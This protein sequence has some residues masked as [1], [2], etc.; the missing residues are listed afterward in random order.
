MK[1][2]VKTNSGDTDI[3]DC[4][5]DDAGDFPAALLSIRPSCCCQAGLDDTVLR[6]TDRNPVRLGAKCRW[7]H[8]TDDAPWRENAIWPSFV[9]ILLITL[10]AAG[11]GPTDSRDQLPPSPTEKS[12]PINIFA[13]VRR[14]LNSRDWA[15]AESLLNQHLENQPT[16]PVALTLAGDLAAQLGKW[17]SAIDH[18]QNLLAI[19][20]QPASVAVRDKLAQAWMG[21]GQPF[22]SIAV[23]QETIQKFPAAVETR[24][25]LAG[26][27]ALLGLETPAVESL[28]WLAQHNQGHPEGL[29][30]LAHPSRLEPDIE[31]CQ[32]ALRNCPEDRRAEYGMARMDAINRRW[33][34]VVDRLEPVVQQRPD[35]VPAIALYGRAIVE[36]GDTERIVKWQQSL[37][38]A[39]ETSALFWETAGR[40]AE[41]QGDDQAAAKAFWKAVQHDQANNSQTLVRLAASLEKI[42]RAD[43][44][45][46][47]ARRADKIAAL[48]DTTNTFFERGSRSQT[49]AMRVAGQ[50]VQL[51]RLWEAEGWARWALEL[52]DEPVADAKRQYISIRSKLTAQTPW[53][54]ASANVT[55]GINLS[56]LPNV[57]W[58]I[59][60]QDPE[61]NSLVNGI[62]KIRF[63]DQAESRRLMHTC[64][65]AAGTEEKGM[66]I[67]QSVGGGA[68][69]LDFDLN[70]WPD[71]SF[72][73]LD[74]QPMQTDSKLNRLFQNLDGQ[75][76]DVTNVSGYLDH[77]FGQGV[78]V[79]DINGDGFPDLLDAN[80]G[81]NRLFQNNGDG[82][83]TDVTQNYVPATVQQDESH[84][85]AADW[86]TSVAIA[87]LNGDGH[88][89][90]YEANYC[91]GTQPY[92]KACRVEKT[93]QLASCTPLDFRAQPD[94]VWAGKGDGT[95]T[96]VTAE[97]MP[98][99]DPGRGL[100]L[101]VGQL[102]QRPGLDIYVA[103]DMTRNQLLSPDTSSNQFA[104]SDLATLSGLAVNGRS[105]SQASMGMAVGDPD[106]DG[107][108][109]FFLT[110]FSDD[111][112]TYYE[113]VS[114]GIW[115]DRSYAVDLGQSSEPMLGFGTE[116]VDFDNNGSLELIIANGHVSDLQH[117][118]RSFKMPTQVFARANDG[119]WSE[120]NGDSLGDYFTKPH[121][122]RALVSLDANQD[123]KVDVAV[124]QIFE[125]VALLM[126]Q[127]ESDSKGLGLLFVAT[128]SHRDA[129]GTTVT[130]KIDGRKHFAQLTGGD[131]FMCS[132]QRRLNIGMGTSQKATDIVVTWPSGEQQNFDAI[133]SGGDYLIV[134]GSHHPYRLHPHR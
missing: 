132:N 48:A 81:R 109:D 62:G 79:G 40:W 112:N 125:P 88:A 17:R 9:L 102:D 126:N 39:I 118:G 12:S 128:D 11:C 134:E 68:A 89:D 49:I 93:G 116:W 60:D 64:E 20:D 75:Y 82:T 114:A 94:R 72:A 51:G 61:T 53:Q 6:H 115:Q 13:E 43:E 96:D 63:V 105:I 38:A 5:C 54:L 22:E 30:L 86:T 66:W 2:R 45:K 34:Q 65:L 107:D 8:R 58:A 32:A 74:G 31:V 104:Y 36:L 108:L 97:W 121:L 7:G 129:V 133:E 124:T 90:L 26:L 4:Q 44:A 100:G 28:K 16:D 101:I 21:A 85:S 23:L 10:A 113:Q 106:A 127:T 35:F 120:M 110:H 111:H 117:T 42:S 70:G 50:M 131:G 59:R 57:T 83:F 91:A 103:N 15:R 52:P 80:I 98:D 29:V 92:E 24:F 119:K 73:M 76:G 1:P 47:V 3:T 14:A 78:T 99:Q 77:G 87:D 71:V 37:P 25:D 55:A 41:R 122:G 95:F 123:G 130:M 67:Y 33:D 19:Q 56:A 84:P 27:A 69:V 46:V 18:Y